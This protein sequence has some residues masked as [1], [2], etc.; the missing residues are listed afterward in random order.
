MAALKTAGSLLNMGQ[1]LVFDQINNPSAGADLPFL[2]HDFPP[3]PSTHERYWIEP[4][5]SLE[6]RIKPFGRHDILGLLTTSSTDHEHSWR[7]VLTTDDV[8]W[9]REHKMQTL[10]TFPLAGYLSMVIEAAAQRV[11]L[12]RIAFERFCLREV[13]ATAPLIMNDGEEYETMV[14]LRR[15]A[16]GTR[17]YSNEWDEFQISSWAPGRGWIEH[18]RGLVAVRKSSSNP[19]SPSAQ[20]ESGKRLRLA[21]ERCNDVVSLDSF[22]AEL[23]SKGA[24]YGPLFQIRDKRGLQCC[25]DY[26]HSDVEVPNTAAA[27]QNGHGHKTN[28]INGH[29]NGSNGVNG[30]ANGVN[31]NGVNGVHGVNGHANGAS[32]LATDFAAPV[33]IV[34]DKTENDPMVRS[35]VDLLVLKTGASPTVCPL[36]KLVA[37][38]KVC[39]DPQEVQ[40]PAGSRR[41]RPLG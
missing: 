33:V 30:H 31:G 8:P 22:Y 34:S 19:V 16:E 25:D 28:G 2:V 41:A 6:T 38:D 5:Q 12:R 18:C 10:T 9:L 4:R 36:D 24:G 14:T 32:A 40:T 13:Q 37:S 15:Y 20:S 29:T 3:Y 39:L 27:M 21:T 1:K 7:N 17:S 26:C 11:S 23:E 35:L